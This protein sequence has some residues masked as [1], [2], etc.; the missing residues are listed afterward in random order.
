[1]KDT[2]KGGGNE[3]GGQEGGI[4]VESVDAKAEVSQEVDTGHKGGSI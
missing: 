2:I 1:M 4:Y 3:G